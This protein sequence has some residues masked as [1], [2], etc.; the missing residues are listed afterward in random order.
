[1]ATRANDVKTSTSKNG[2]ATDPQAQTRAMRRSLL[3][4]ALA[5]VIALLHLAAVTAVAVAGGSNDLVTLTMLS[6]GIITMILV[7]GATKRW[8]RWAALWMLVI[9][10]VTAEAAAP[11]LFV[12]TAWI[13]H[14]TWTVEPH[15]PIRGSRWVCG[16]FSRAS[17]RS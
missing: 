9:G 11:V 12:G 15:R 8:Y 13:L 7:P 6:P 16:L 5:I 4:G 2:P 1:M 17:G 3:L 14:L 10:G